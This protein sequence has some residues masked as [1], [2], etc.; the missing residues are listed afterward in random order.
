M[1][2]DFSNAQ[3]PRLPPL[4]ASFEEN[5]VEA[6]LRKIFIDLF[7]ARMAQDSFDAN[8]MGVAHLGSLSLVQ[9]SINMDGLVLLQGDR[10]EAATRYLYRAWKSGDVQGR[11]VHF[12][13]TYLQLLFPGLCKVEQLWQDKLKTYPSDMIP[14]RMS[15]R[16]WSIR[17]GDAGLKIDGAWVLGG[18]KSDAQYAAAIPHPVDMTGMFLTSR[19]EVAMVLR[20]DAESVSRLEKIISSVVPARLFPVF[21][22]TRLFTL[23]MTRA[24]TTA[25]I[26]MR[27][28]TA[29][30]K[31][32]LG[33]VVTSDPSRQWRLGAEGYPSWGLGTG[34]VTADIGITKH[35]EVPAYMTP[36]LSTPGLLV[37]G[38]WRVGVARIPKFTFTLV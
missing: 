28:K 33:R 5:S 9:K 32:F 7:N 18:V 8:V 17:L 22:F 30:R 29:I 34:R 36:R 1:A 25:H 6:D 11:G 15:D 10:E 27:K 13:R 23:D 24:L 19:V 38:T 20:S 4:G 26:Y 16:S 14:A 3:L 35:I 2:L 21:K 12:L 31:P 37:N